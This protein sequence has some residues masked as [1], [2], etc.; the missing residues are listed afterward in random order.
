MEDFEPA[1]PRPARFEGNRREIPFIMLGDKAY[2]PKTYLMKHFA[3]KGLSCEERVF[4]CGPSQERDVLSV[5][6]VF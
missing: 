4:N 6:L 5:R 1:L 3:R 2:P